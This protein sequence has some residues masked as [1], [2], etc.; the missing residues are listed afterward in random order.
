MALTTDTSP[1]AAVIQPERVA[2]RTITLEEHFVSRR[3]I[4]VAGIDLGAQRGLDLS[5]SEVTDLAELRLHHMDESGID[6]QVI[7]HAPIPPSQ[8][9]DIATAANDQAAA[10]IAAHPSRF[11]AFATLPM[12]DP[13]AA[14]AEL[15]RAVTQLGFVGAL[16][17]GRAN[18]MFLDAPAYRPLLQAVVDLDVPLYLHPGLPTATPPAERYAG[19]GPSV[20]YVL[21]TTAWGSAAETGLHALRLIAAGIFDELPNLQIILGH[22]GEM[23]PFVLNRA[24]EWLTP[25]ARTENNLQLS[26]AETFRRNFW[27][28]TSGMFCSP[29]LLLLHQVLGPDRL[30][31][32]IDYPFNSNAQGRAFLDGLEINP[33]DK[34]KLSHRNAER[35]LRLPPTA[36]ASPLPRADQ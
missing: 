25:A 24:D 12:S 30:L 27:I 21:A 29:Q 33:T 2:M 36:S 9:Q 4:D 5:S 22:M 23:I 13:Q 6:M 20:G 17:S 14:V 15:R 3:F 34:E 8:D 31:F 16:I 26:V 32:S 11:A 35:L 18:D 28:T 7:S 19:F 1:A 10:A